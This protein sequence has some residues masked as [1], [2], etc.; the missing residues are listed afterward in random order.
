MVQRHGL[1]AQRPERSTR[2]DTTARLASAPWWAYLLLAVLVVGTFGPSVQFEFLSWD[3]QLHVT[4]NRGLN[5]PSLE[6]VIR[7][8]RNPYCGLYAPL[9]YTLYALEAWVGRTDA[10]P[11]SRLDARIFHAIN[12][13]LHAWAT[14]LAFGVVRQMTRHNA[15][16]L[17]GA[18]IFAIHPMQV[19]SVAWVSET[20]G[21][22][23]AAFSLGAIWWLVRVTQHDANVA[24][25]SLI[26]IGLCTGLALLAKPSAAGIPLA[27]GL[28]GI[29]LQCDKRRLAML[30]GATGFM[31]LAVAWVTKGQQS[32]ALMHEVAPLWLRPIMALNY[33]AFYA[34]RLAWPVPLG[35]DYGW[36]ASWLAGQWWCYLLWPLPIAAGYLLFRHDKGRQ[37]SSPALV[38]CSLLLPV[39]GLVPFG[40]QEISSVADRYA[41]LP[42]LAVAWWVAAVLVAPRWNFACGFIASAVLALFVGLSLQQVGHWRNDTT[43]YTQM[44]RVN[45]DSFVAHMNL[46]IDAARSG[47][48]L[49]AVA[50]QRRATELN[51]RYALA[52]FNLGSTQLQ[53]GDYREAV[54][55]LARANA[56][57]PHKL[58]TLSNLGRALIELKQFAP[59]TNVLQQAVKVDPHSQEAHTNL[60]DAY[61][62]QRELLSAEQHARMATELDPDFSDAWLILSAVRRQQGRLSEAKQILQQSLARRSKSP[63]VEYALG[64]LY[65]LNEE[66]G[67]AESHFQ[68]AAEFNPNLPQAQYQQAF[69]RLQ[70]GE[71]NEA[72]KQFEALVAAYPD[73]VDPFHGLAQVM[74][75]SG[76]TE[77]AIAL[78]QHALTIDPSWA[79]AQQSL[80]WIYATTPE[81][82]LRDP[83]AA[84]E[85]AQ[86]LLRR[87]ENPGPELLDVVAAVQAA[88]GSF[89]EAVAN[90]EK[91]AELARQLGQRPLQERIER[92]LGLY[93]AGEAFVD[94]QRTARVARVR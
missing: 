68:R 85:K 59:A 17:V 10:E 62:R 39:S 38:F 71:I 49:E 75:R 81:A 70:R 16:A 48:M 7:F 1:F 58:E 52:W 33:L 11:G 40:F 12:V 78:Y 14:L 26:G 94:R 55:A 31:A 74:L 88:N 9:S 84:Q 64:Q 79:M 69:C 13:I 60:A 57:Q 5:P 25:R 21:L 45:P 90:G 4:Q 65:M 61:L 91:A 36:R 24:P 3:D 42:M 73:Y 54:G 50:L 86:E 83:K 76:E 53:L 22:L 19:E 15:A 27:L 72:V 30:V 51:P 43:L 32:D 67:A 44:L 47:R 56:L 66:W 6:N 93:R 37:T 63:G 18:A 35:P 89:A 77:R 8:W 46:G 29:H 87:I 23:A 2:G 80:A 20:R 28:V 41:Y 34:A 82:S 92:R